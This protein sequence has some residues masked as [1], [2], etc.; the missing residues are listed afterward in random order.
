MARRS[1]CRAARG[2]GSSTRRTGR[3][4]VVPSAPAAADPAEPGGFGYRHWCGSGHRP[5]SRRRR[6]QC[7]RLSRAAGLPAGKRGQRTARGGWLVF[8]CRP[9]DGTTAAL[10]SGLCRRGDRD[11]LRVPVTRARPLA[12]QSRPGKGGRPR[13][14][15]RSRPESSLPKK[16]CSGRARASALSSVDPS[17][18]QLWV[19]SRPMD[20]LA[21]PEQTFQPDHDDVVGALVGEARYPAQLLRPKQVRLPSPPPPSRRRVQ[22]R[23]SFPPPLAHA[24][25]PPVSRCRREARLAAPSR[26][27]YRALGSSLVDAKIGG[28]ALRPS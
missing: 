1:D 14:P 23:P 10:P 3:P 2:A 16:G 9:A 17:S 26:S 11:S 21:A 19:A 6:R 15:G 7:R 18:S 4:L 12:R 25:W 24:P 22:V 8:P 20:S 27:L 28:W 5:R 13:V